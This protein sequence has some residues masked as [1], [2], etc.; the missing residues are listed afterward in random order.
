MIWF[1]GGKM[2]VHFATLS[3]DLAYKK[4]KSV[5]LRRFPTE[6]E[7]KELKKSKYKL[8]DE[9][10]TT[11][12]N[13][14]ELKM[15]H[16]P[17]RKYVRVFSG[18]NYD[19]K[20]GGTYGIDIDIKIKHAEKEIID[21]LCSIM[22]ELC[23]KHLKKA[24]VF[25]S[26][27][28]VACQIDECKLT[29]DKVKLFL[30]DFVM[31]LEDM[32]GEFKVTKKEKKIEDKAEEQVKKYEEIWSKDKPL[33]ELE[34][35]DEKIEEKK[36]EKENL[37]HTCAGTASIILGIFG[38]ITLINWLTIFENIQTDVYAQSLYLTQYIYESPL[39]FTIRFWTGNEFMIWVF[40]P[41][42]LG[43]SAIIFGRKAKRQN[44]NYGKYGMIIGIVATIIGL[45]QLT[46]TLYLFFTGLHTY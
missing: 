42:I 14:L 13:Q 24:I 22:R 43:I 30:E 19:F 32:I 7:T 15:Y 34:E 10:V 8:V 25:P 36:T 23:K 9:E 46:S 35:T 26:M 5:V 40:I 4:E 18:G 2:R 38:L 33:P 28:S 16:N 20:E 44:D 45:I 17:R 39:D 1:E 31:N 12:D 41:L 27:H 29:H 6:Y 11:T 37:E 21:Y 3:M